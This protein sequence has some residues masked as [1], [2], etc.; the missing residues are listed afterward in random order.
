[1]QLPA[2]RYWEVFQE[3]QVVSKCYYPCSLKVEDTQIKNTVVLRGLFAFILG[4]CL[5]TAKLKGE[6]KSSADLNCLCEV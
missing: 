5:Y 1:M 4:G 2:G 3:I 6:E